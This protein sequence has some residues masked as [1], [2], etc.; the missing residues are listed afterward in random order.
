MLTEKYTSDN[1]MIENS[2]DKGKAV[3]S[4]HDPLLL[5]LQEQLETQKAEQELLNEEVKNLTESHHH[6]IKTQE[7]I[8]SKLDVILAHISR[9]S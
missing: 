7:D 4:E 5:K 8:S 1:M 9:Q 2:K 3:A 6:V